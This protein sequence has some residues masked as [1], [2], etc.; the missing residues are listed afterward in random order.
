V[1]QIYNENVYDLLAS[2]SEEDWAKARE[3]L[4]LQDR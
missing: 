3:A 1:L 4:K 2:K